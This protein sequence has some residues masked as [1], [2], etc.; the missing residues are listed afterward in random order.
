MPLLLLDVNVLPSHL[1]AA[2]SVNLQA[3]HAVGE[4]R[5]GVIVIRNLNAIQMNYDVIAAEPRPQGHSTRLALAPAP[6]RGRH[7]HPASAS[8]L[9]KP[10]G[11]FA[12]AGIHLHLH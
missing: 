5:R 11:V 12:Y 8:T 4:F 2:A 1:N 9:V 7:D 3:D 10:A 6:L